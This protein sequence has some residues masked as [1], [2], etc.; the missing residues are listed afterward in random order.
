MQAFERVQKARAALIMSQPFFGSLALKLNLI[1]RSDIETMAVDGR[2]LFFNPGFVDGTSDDHL[3]TIVAHETMHCALCH[4]T[5]RGNR[6]PDKWNEACDYAVNPLLVTSGFTMPDEALCSP[7]YSDMSA[8]AIF[9]KRSQPDDEDGDE[10]SSGNQGDGGQ[11]SQSG[12]GEGDEQGDGEGNAAPDPGGMGG[13]LDAPPNDNG[14]PLSETEQ[15]DLE[16]EWQVAVT[17]AAQLERAQGDLSAELDRAVKDMLEPKADWRELLRQFMEAIAKSDYSW[18]PPNRRFAHEGVYLPGM[19]SETL[20]PIVVA[21]DTSGSVRQEDLDQFAAE[22][23]V[24]LEEA[25]PEELHVVYCD[26]QLKGVQTFEPDDE[27]DLKAKGGGGT[28]FIP[29]FDWVEDNDIEPVCL[30][31]LT[32]LES[33]RFP[34]DPGYPVLWGVYGGNTS[35]PPFGDVVE[36]D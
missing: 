1:E 32:D 19:R 8:E 35:Q 13:V 2:N 25:R 31:Y 36:L 7:E 11:G 33:S 15:A 23:T 4:M 24:I 16:R 20:P 30:I 17:Q 27:I 9:S 18:T 26:S 21:V 3:K 14:Q 5:R 6:A 10:G 12:Q 28:S 34:D 29:P 22:L